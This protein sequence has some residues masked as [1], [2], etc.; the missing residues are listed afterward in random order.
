MTFFYNETFDAKLNVNVL[1]IGNFTLGN[2]VVD[3]TTPARA[4]SSCS[5]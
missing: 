3:L 1:Q 5:R 2:A 4:R